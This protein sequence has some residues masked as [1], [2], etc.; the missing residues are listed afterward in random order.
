M[1]RMDDE[2]NT[3][4]YN[5]IKEDCPWNEERKIGGYSCDTCM[6]GMECTQENCA[7]LKFNIYFNRPEVN[8]G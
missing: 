2:K 5:A 4:I 1:A 6:V 3:M 8:N 7:P